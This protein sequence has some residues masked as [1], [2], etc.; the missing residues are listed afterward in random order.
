MEQIKMALVELNRFE[1]NAIAEEI[2][3]YSAEYKNSKWY[4]KPT[5]KDVLGV[6]KAGHFDMLKKALS[7]ND[8]ALIQSYLNIFGEIAKCYGKS[9]YDEDLKC[10]RTGYEYETQL[11]TTF[12]NI[13]AIAIGKPSID[14]NTYYEGYGSC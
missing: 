3:G 1:E 6:R 12:R 10:Y 9:W 4:K 14:L 13:A 2:Q 8:I 11:Y 7:N 5:I